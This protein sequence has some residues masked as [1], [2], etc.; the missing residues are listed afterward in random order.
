[1]K[2]NRY[3]FQQP[4]EEETQEILDP[5]DR[6]LTNVI[7]NLIKIDDESGENVSTSREIMTTPFDDPCDNPILES[8]GD[9]ETDQMT[10]S[11]TD[12]CENPQSWISTIESRCLSPVKTL[13][14]TATS[15]DLPSAMDNGESSESSS[16]RNLSKKCNDDDREIMKSGSIPSSPIVTVANTTSTMSVFF[17]GPIS[18]APSSSIK[19]VQFSNPLIVGPSNRFLAPVFGATATELENFTDNCVTSSSTTWSCSSTMS[20]SREEEPMEGREQRFFKPIDNVADFDS[21]SVDSSSSL[22]TVREFPATNINPMSISSSSMSSRDELRES[23]TSSQK[24][25][26]STK[27][28]TSEEI[29]ATR[30]DRLKRL[31]EQADWLMK[32]MNATNKRGTAL[33]TRLEELHDTYGEPP[34]PPPMPDVLPSYRL[35]SIL[36]NLPHQVKTYDNFVNELSSIFVLYINA[37]T[38]LVDT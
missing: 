27:S 21:I 14:R 19:S 8:G 36:P 30:A 26:T 7:Q 22:D 15:V 5:L 11:R 25:A 18:T 12:F 32:K 16:T 24:E 20:S 13:K 3:N 34:V 4:I 37:L 28:R 1:M 31:E 38:F 17:I 9:M 10:I 29:L 23:A 33:C 2:T 35:P 6:A